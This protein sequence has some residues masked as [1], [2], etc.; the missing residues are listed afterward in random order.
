[1]AY[2]AKQT[3]LRLHIRISIEVAQLN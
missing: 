1:V 3:V 2:T